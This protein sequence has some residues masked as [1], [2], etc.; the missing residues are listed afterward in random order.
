MPPDFA[1]RYAELTVAD[2]T[3]RALFPTGPGRIANTGVLLRDMDAAEIDHSVVMGF[4]WTDCRIARESNDYLLSAQRANP[5]RITAFCSVNPAWGEPAVAEAKRTIDKG[6]AGIGE[7]H[8]DTQGFSLDDS[9]TLA[10]VMEVLREAG[11]PVTIHASEPVGHQ[12]PGKGTATP[13]K[14]LRFA[15]SFPENQIIMAHLGG[16]LPFYAAMPE[17]Q[18]A[19]A[20]VWF[21]TA[22]I[23]YLYRPDAVAAAAITAGHD[24]ILFGSD[25]PLLKPRRVIDHVTSAALTAEQRGKILGVNALS[26]LGKNPYA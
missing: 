8:S 18:A 3:F 15:S 20:N 2:A 26:L 19:L 25:Y 11:L 5:D 13:D 7:L 22:A 24:R 9:E 6:A 17:V 4:G 23:P 1:H 12:Y 21:D 16:G 10:P 14:L